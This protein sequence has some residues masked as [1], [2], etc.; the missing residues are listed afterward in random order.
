MLK[1]GRGLCVEN[2][3]CT[4]RIDCGYSCGLGHLCLMSLWPHLSQD[5]GGSSFCAS[6]LIF[7]LL[8]DH[9]GFSV[10]NCGTTNNVFG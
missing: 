7:S 1:T 8:K 3:M 10:P 2:N 5:P 9:I 4:G 6:W